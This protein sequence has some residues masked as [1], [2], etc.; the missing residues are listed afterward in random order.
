MRNFSILSK[1]LILGAIVSAVG[2]A[3]ILYL[4]N[5]N[6]LGVSSAVEKTR[7]KLIGE[8]QSK[9]D[10]KYFVQFKKIGTS[11]PYY[12]YYDDEIVDSGA[13]MVLT[14]LAGT[15]FADLPQ[16]IYLKKVAGQPTSQEPPEAFYYSV[17]FSDDDKILLLTYLDRGNTLIF[18]K[19]SR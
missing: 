10:Q 18:G 5:R 11:S 17:E 12:D 6:G 7:D 1:V 14:A 15:K 4:Q 19:V 2:L 13:W 8:W 16:G 9:E 3:Y